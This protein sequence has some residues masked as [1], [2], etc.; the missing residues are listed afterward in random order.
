MLRQT[1]RMTSASKVSPSIVAQHRIRMM[2]SWLGARVNMSTTA[3]SNDAVEADVLHRK[4]LSSRTFILNRPKSLNALNL[5]M[6]R[7]MTPQLQA[8]DASDLCKVIVIK[9]A[10]GKAFCAGGDVRLVVEQ[11]MAQKQDEGLTFFAEEYKLN[12][13]IATL[14]TPFVAILDGIT[15][16][17]G[18]GL[19]VHAPFR[20]ATEKTLFAMPETKIGLFPD[21]GGS[22]FLPRLDGETGTYLGLVGT[23]LK[24]I[25]TVFAGIATHYVPSERLAAL[26]DRL[27]ELETDNHDVINMAIE[28]FVSEPKHGHKYALS[29]N[30]DAIDRC[31]RFNTVE[32]ILAALEKEN[33]PFGTQTLKTLRSMSPTSLKV[34]LQQLREGANLGIADCFRM[35]HQLAGQFLYGHDFIEG[36]KALLIEKT[37][38]PRWDPAT[39]EEV[40]REQMLGVYFR[41]QPTKA[42]SLTSNSSFR[43]YPYRRYALP[44]ENEIRK[45][46]TGEA[47]GS[48][49]LQLTAD[50]VV[51]V[52]V[53]KSG[54]KIGVR[55]KVLEVLSRK[56]TKGPDGELKWIN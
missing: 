43:E 2:N 46:V 7:N 12:H 47:Q 25:D 33:T 32:E 51:E 41:N 10:G 11:A 42:L 38:N 29:E 22:F 5:S 23:Q 40:D 17:G 9:G 14:K 4:H 24:G 50:E 28:D 13:M 16:G 36:V 20:I 19:S 26:E 18:V 31:F 6:V 52:C 21:V 30:R 8:W 39:V 37:L 45:I 56:V 44:S 49:P 35:E 55:E 3:A 34:T 53:K 48:G 15:M 1:F 27:S 54:G